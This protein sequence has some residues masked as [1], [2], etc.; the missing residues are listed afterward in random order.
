MGEDEIA[1]K[2]KKKRNTKRKKVREIKTNT[3]VLMFNSLV[4]PHKLKVGFLS[5]DMNALILNLLLWFKCQK[6]NH[7]NDNCK[8][9]VTCF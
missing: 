6:Y 1:L 2:H 8:T 3:C 4:P 5:F 7:R 9:E